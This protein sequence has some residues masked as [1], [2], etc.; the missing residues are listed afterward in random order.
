[1]NVKVISR[2]TLFALLGGLVF[3]PA[4]ETINQEQQD[5]PSILKRWI[6]V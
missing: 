3:L 5:G 2:F 1:M 4:E 6:P